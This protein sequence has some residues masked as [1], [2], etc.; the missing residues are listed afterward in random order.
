MS[1]YDPINK[2]TNKKIQKTYQDYINNYGKNKVLNLFS[3][4]GVDGHGY[5]DPVTKKISSK[6]NMLIKGAIE[7]NPQNFFYRMQGG[8]CECKKK[9][10]KIYH[11]ENSSSES[12]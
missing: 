2:D 9:K 6:N 8:N 4:I 1:Y 3:N 5:V 7:R 10:K 11:D 12:D